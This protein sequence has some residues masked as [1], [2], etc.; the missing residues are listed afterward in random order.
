MVERIAKILITIFAGIAGFLAKKIGNPGI[1]VPADFR[2]WLDIFAL[3]MIP[4]T[5]VAGRTQYL[6]AHGREDG[7]VLLNTVRVKGH[8]R[9]Y[10]P[11]AAIQE[12]ID[13]DQICLPDL[14]L[15][16]CFNGVRKDF[17]YHGV[18]VHILPYTQY[19]RICVMGYYKGMF[20][21]DARW[22]PTLPSRTLIAI[23]RPFVYMKAC[24]KLFVKGF[25]LAK[26]GK[27]C[28]E[29]VAIVKGENKI[30]A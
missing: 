14:V 24:T 25:K 15:I 22:L 6:M 2:E 16:S 3:K 30:A 11:E 20:Y 12:L 4:C 10:S 8:K 28:K 23:C 5:W 18:Y 1:P 29:V 13:L 26:E 7:A 9:W 27:S 17:Y 21:P 19:K